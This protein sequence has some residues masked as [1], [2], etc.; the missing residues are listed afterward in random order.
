MINLFSAAICGVIYS[1]D[2]L[3]LNLSGYTKCY[4]QPYSDV[5]TTSDLAACKGS[6]WV[7]VGA[8]PSSSATNIVLGAFGYSSTVYTTTSSTTTA[9]LDRY[10]GAYWC[11]FPLYGCG[12]SGVPTVHILDCDYA[13]LAGDCAYRLCWNLDYSIRGYRVGCLEN[14]NT[15]PTWR[16]VMYKGNQVNTCAPGN[17]ILYEI[18]L[19][20]CFKW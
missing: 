3:T 5:T 14:L 9:Y 18:L 13:Q 20:N 1:Y 4:D 2:E 11:N 17:V 19:L 6:T 15:D 10:G 8:K 12:F 16:K 7:F